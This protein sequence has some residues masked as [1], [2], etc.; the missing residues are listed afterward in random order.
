MHSWKKPIALTI[1]GVLML[2]I[3]CYIFT[4]MLGNQ[5]ASFSRDFPYLLTSGVLMG[6]GLIALLLGAIEIMAKAVD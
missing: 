6:I 3:G 4:M 5:H 1:A 2:A